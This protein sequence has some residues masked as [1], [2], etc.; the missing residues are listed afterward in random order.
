MHAVFK[1]FDNFMAVFVAVFGV[2]W[3]TVF[4]PLLGGPLQTYEAR[5]IGVGWHSLRTGQAANLA[6]ALQIAASLPGE[7]VF[8]SAHAAE[9]PVQIAPV[10]LEGETLELLGGPEVTHIV[11]AARRPAPRV[12]EARPVPSIASADVE[13]LAEVACDTSAI[14]L[15]LCAPFAADP[16]ASTSA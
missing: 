12:D 15:G 7:A 11:V 8:P 3:S 16:A 6:E 10:E 13:P 14:K 9:P 1:S 5:A 4:M 2:V